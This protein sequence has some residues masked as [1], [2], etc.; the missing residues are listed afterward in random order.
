M[1]TRLYFSL[2]F[3]LFLMGNSIAKKEN[4]TPVGV[5]LNKII[6]D[7]LSSLTNHM[8]QLIKNGPSE[9]DLKKFA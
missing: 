4:N 2:I 8:N 3:S 1:R 9:N 7:N 5:K 6:N